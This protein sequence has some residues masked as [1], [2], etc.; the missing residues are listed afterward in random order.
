MQEN[1]QLD[2]TNPFQAVSEIFYKPTAVFNTL[3]V[4]D[5]WSWIPFILVLAVS[6][7]PAFL[8]FNVVDFDWYRAIIAQTQMPE[9]SPAELE[10]FANTMAQGT[11]QLITIVSVAIGLPIV[12]ALLAGY[13]AL[14]TRNDEKSVHGFTD[15]YGATWWMS[16][17]TV[18]NALLACLYMITQSIGTELNQAAMAP[19]SLAFIFGTDMTASWYGLLSA[20]RIDSIWSIVLGA[21]CLSSWTNF[22]MVK[23]VL[24]SALPSAIIWSIMIAVA[25]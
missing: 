16:M 18:I 5:N 17:P 14:W 7:V 2:V 25:L 8:Y 22:S 19:L 9:A 15:W 6:V 11:T 1:T 12:M 21:I 10:A 4:K 24:V 13:Y 20:L 3:A 23:S